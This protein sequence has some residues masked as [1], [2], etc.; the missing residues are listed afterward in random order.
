MSSTIQDQVARAAKAK[1]GKS[2]G[3]TLK[4]IGKGLTVKQVAEKR[5]LREKQV[6]SHLYDAV[7]LGKLGADVFMD[8]EENELIRQYFFEV[9]SIETKSALKY[10]DGAF[11]Y[12]E[13]NLVRNE[14]IHE[15]RSGR[16]PQAV[17]SPVNGEFRLVLAQRTAESKEGDGIEWIIAVI[18]SKKWEELLQLKEECN[19]NDEWDESC[20]RHVFTEQHD[21]YERILVSGEVRRA[22]SLVDAYRGAY[23]WLHE[24]N[25]NGLCAMVHRDRSKCR[26][27]AMKMAQSAWSESKFKKAN[28]GGV[29]NH[30][31]S[32]L[33]VGQTRFSVKRRYNRHRGKIKGKTI[34]GQRHFLTP[35]S[36]AHDAEVL[37]L[38]GEYESELGVSLSRMPYGQSIIHEEGFAL[39]LK[40]RGY[41]VY[42]A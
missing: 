25:A 15:M 33:Y 19:G 31:G 1:W 24:L 29:G 30:A 6:W 23:D 20:H 26:V 37:R 39:W 42:F 14:V 9:D 2:L 8:P 40:S 27:Y 10:F 34:W 41:A 4:M 36:A 38:I 7:Q 22:K 17:A 32:P 21:R 13:L 3:K 28:P 18:K 11:D 16:S 35:F 5:G 12:P